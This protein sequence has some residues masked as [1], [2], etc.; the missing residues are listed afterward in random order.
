VR[1]RPLASYFDGLL[2]F[3]V[4]SEWGRRPVTRPQARSAAGCDGER[5]AGVRLPVST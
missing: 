2:D 5:D 4:A 1:P 3:A